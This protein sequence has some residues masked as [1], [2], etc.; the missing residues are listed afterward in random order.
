M[1]LQSS[2]TLRV[3][4]TFT[5]YHQMS[6]SHNFIYIHRLPSNLVRFCY[7]SSLKDS[8]HYFNPSTNPGYWSSSS[9]PNI[10][11]FHPQTALSTLI[12]F[13]NFRSRRPLFSLCWRTEELHSIY[14]FDLG[15]IRS[16]LLARISTN[17]A[18]DV[19]PSQSMLYV[20]FDL[21]PIWYGCVRHNVEASA[22]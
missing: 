4:Q 1:R 5:L 6:S 3:C 17:G 12:K 11:S 15:R 14:G 22:P 13:N 20:L 8:H 21:L 7:R 19:W 2:S 10:I 9:P 18:R 16:R